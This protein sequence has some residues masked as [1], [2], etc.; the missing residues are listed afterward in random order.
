[1][2]SPQYELN[3]QN[4]FKKSRI[5]CYDL[6]FKD[7]VIKT[8][9]LSLIMVCTKKLCSYVLDKRFMITFES[10]VSFFYHAEPPFK[11]F[12]YTIKFNRFL[13]L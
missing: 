2:I 4:S 13:L 9:C 1:M 8:R 6:L 12:N 3:K 5:S 7:F 10:L 11:W